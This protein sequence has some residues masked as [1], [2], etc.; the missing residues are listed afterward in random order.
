MTR[1]PRRL[2]MIAFLVAIVVAALAPVAADAADGTFTDDDNSIFE[3]DIEWMAGN[4]YTYGCNPPDNDMFC[5]D[6]PVTRGQ[7]AAFMSRALGLTDGV[8]A[9]LFTDDDNSIFESAI[10]RI[11]TVGITLGC[12]P[13]DNDMFCPD[14]PVTRGQMAAFMSRALGLTD[15]VGADL[16]TD[17]DNSIFESAIDRIGTVGVTLG[18]NPPDNDMYCPNDPVTRGQM[19]AFLHRGLADV[20]LQLLAFND[21]HGHLQ[22][23][24]PGQVDG[25]SAGGSEYLS[26]ALSELRAG[27]ENTLTVAAGDLI[28]GS[29]AFSGLFHD[30][31]SVESLNAMGLDVS[32][33][34]NHEFDEGVTELLRMQQGGCH[35]VDGCYFR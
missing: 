13:P 34:G 23:S 25:E 28:G 2:T 31:P 11:G 4:G 29:P 35:P 16:F 27:H 7:M 1:A 33:V 5:P 26:T 15:G 22:S 17:D 14:D 19:A 6:D 10:D 24:T 8:G 18:C 21:Y 3:A 12:N 9:D 20:E 30:E 32:S